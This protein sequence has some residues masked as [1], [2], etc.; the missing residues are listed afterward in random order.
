Y[1][2][3]AD[4]REERGDL[5]LALAEIRSGIEL[6][7]N[8]VPLHLRSGDIALKL[9]KTDA[10]LKEYTTVLQYDPG[11]AEAVKG[12]TRAYVLKAQKEAN[13]AFFMSNNYEAAE[14]MIQQAI[15]MNPNDM[16]LRLVDAKF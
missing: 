4:I 5:E 15:R 10:A 1:M 16:E 7:P 13:G 8:S 11:S 3:L 6:N 12:M 14:G 2:G 9:E